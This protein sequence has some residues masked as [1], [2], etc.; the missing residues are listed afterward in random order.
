MEDAL[1]AALRETPTVLAVV[2]I[3]VVSVLQFS[4][5]TMKLADTANSVCV[6]RIEE[7]EATAQTQ[8]PPS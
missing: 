1:I 8:K 5:V 3:A 7:E 4:K 2:T 6:E